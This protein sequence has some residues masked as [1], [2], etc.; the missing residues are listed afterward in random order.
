MAITIG[1]SLF[2]EPFLPLV[3]DLTRVGNYAEKDFGWHT[4][5]P[6]LQI[7]E[8]GPQIADPDVLVLGDSF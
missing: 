1:L 2:F 5:K 3:G 8:N 6:I 4:P 7:E